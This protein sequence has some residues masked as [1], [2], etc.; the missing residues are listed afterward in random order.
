[1]KENLKQHFIHYKNKICPHSD[2]N[3]IIL[4]MFN[5][6]EI[7]DKKIFRVWKLNNSLL[8]RDTIDKLAIFWEEWRY[9]LENFSSTMDWYLT[10][11]EKVRKTF[12]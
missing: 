2:H 12:D 8:D 5:Q 7:I 10:G 4:N 6:R 9:S 1:M 11:K 3:M